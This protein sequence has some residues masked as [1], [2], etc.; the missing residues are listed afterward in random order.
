MGRA[1]VAQTLQ[2]ILQACNDTF[3][4]TGQCTVEIKKNVEHSLLSRNQNTRQCITTAMPTAHPFMQ[5][6]LFFPLLGRFSCLRT[7][8]SPEFFEKPAF[9]QLLDKRV[10]KDLGRSSPDI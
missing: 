3:A 1:V 7:F 8:S 4:R 10:I 5:S 9:F 6:K 2:R